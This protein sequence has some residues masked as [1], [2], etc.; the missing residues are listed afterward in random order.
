MCDS[1]CSLADHLQAANMLHLI[2][3]DVPLRLP[4]RLPPE[5]RRIPASQIEQTRRTSRWS[6]IYLADGTDLRRADV[7]HPKG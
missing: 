7:R 3:A 2:G 4:G 6:R 5:L 1:G